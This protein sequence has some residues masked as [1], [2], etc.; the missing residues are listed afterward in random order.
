MEVSAAVEAGVDDQGLLVAAQPEDLLD[1]RPVAGIVHAG[2]MDIAEAA[3]G[4]AV[5]F[6]PP[7]EDPAAVEE[8]VLLAQ[9]DG[10][11][12]FLPAMACRRIENGQQGQLAGLAVEQAVVVGRAVQDLA[13]DLLDDMAG[14]DLQGGLVQRAAGQDLGH[15]EAGPGEIIVHE[16]AQRSGRVRRR[17]PRRRIVAAGVGDV[18]LAQQLADHL[19]VIIVVV[20]EGQEFPVDAEIIV[21]VRAVEVGHQELL[22]HLPPHV[23][24][25]VGLLGGLVQDHLAADHDRIGLAALG[26]DLQDAAVDGDEKRLPVGRELQ[27]GLRRAQLAEKL[28]IM[29][30]RL[31]DPEIVALLEAGQVEKLLAVLGQGLVGDVGGMDGQ[32]GLAP[33]DAVELE[34]LVV[35]R[36]QCLDHHAGLVGPGGHEVGWAVI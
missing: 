2:D 9:G 24:V 33:V 16:E 19:G 17:R 18:H 29:R 28:R 25:H 3:A 10:F 23:V 30:A 36:L 21:P 12:H 31:G 34:D 26:V 20:D 13:V 14:F 22:L 11:D 1:D 7:V 27:A 4:Q 6:G 8:A 35:G 32:A 15:L 5:D